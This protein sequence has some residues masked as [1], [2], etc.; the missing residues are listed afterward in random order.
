[1]SLFIYLVFIYLLF[2]FLRSSLKKQEL[3]QSVLCDRY[4]SDDAK[5]CDVFSYFSSHSGNLKITFHKAAPPP[6]QHTLNP[7]IRLLNSTMDVA[8][9]WCKEIHV[10][11]T[12]TPHWPWVWWIMGHIQRRQ[13]LI[14]LLSLRIKQNGFKDQICV[15][16]NIKKQTFPGN[17]C[18]S[19]CYGR[20]DFKVIMNVWIL[21][22]NSSIRLQQ[23]HIFNCLK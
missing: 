16:T 9:S 21:H 2:L 4:T 18:S 8:V 20:G 22:Y 5:I 7:F 3:V 6:Q 10:N 19:I 13:G 17:I 23:R 15:L 14:A 12:L 11:K 1:M